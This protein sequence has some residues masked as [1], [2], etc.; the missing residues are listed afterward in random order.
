MP[1]FVTDPPGDGIAKDPRPL[2]IYKDYVTN[3]AAWLC[4]PPKHHWWTLPG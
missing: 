3:L 2:E 4:G 1:S